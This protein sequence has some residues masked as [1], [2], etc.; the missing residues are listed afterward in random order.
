MEV[1][2]VM[3]TRGQITVGLI[4]LALA[5]IAWLLVLLQEAA[6][7]KLRS[8]DKKQAISDLGHGASKAF[9]AIQAETLHYAPVAKRQTAAVWER[10]I[11]HFSFAGRM[12]RTQFIKSILAA[13]G[14]FLLLMSLGMWLLEFRGTLP[15]T[16]GVMVLVSGLLLYLW[17]SSAACAKRT[18]DTGVTVWWALALLIPPVNLAATIF[19]F[20]V[21][22]DEFAGRGL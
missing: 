17:L 1:L 5:V 7:R 9:G 6:A 16:L 14:C 3:I 11:P 2:G 19:L 22:T 4:V 10:V 13:A 18:R 21:P 8:I 15:D 20:F 12:D